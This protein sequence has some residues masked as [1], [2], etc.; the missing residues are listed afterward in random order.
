MDHE[1]DPKTERKG[2]RKVRYIDRKSEVEIREYYSKFP[3]RKQEYD[4][5]DDEVSS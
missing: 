2:R 3:P 5:D 4:G 1:E